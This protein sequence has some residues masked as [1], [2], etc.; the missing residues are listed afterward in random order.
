MNISVIG[1][2]Y[3]GL[4]TGVGL[5]SKGHNVTCVD[6]VKAKVEQISRGASPIYEK[7]L[8]ELL[9]EVTEKGL[10]KATTDLKS[11]VLNS[12]VSFV[13][14][15]TPSEEDGSI[16][17]KY[18]E[19][20]CEDLGKILKNKEEYHTIVIKS[21]V[22]P[23]TTEKVCLPIIEKASGKPAGKGFGICMSPEFLREGLALEDFLNPARHVIGALDEESIKPLLE[24]YKEFDSPIV[25]TDPTT[26]EM[27]KYAANLFLA[28]K[29][30]YVNEIGNL[31]KRL[32]ADVYKVAEALGLDP[33]ISPHF[34]KAGLGFGGSC[35]P[36]DSRALIAKA[37]ELDYNP[38]LL[39]AILQVNKTQVDRLV[40]IAR[41]KAGPLKDKKVAVLGLA[42]KPATD[43]VRESPAIPL[44]EI[45]LKEYANVCVFDPKAMEHTKKIFG[46][47]I[48]YCGTPEEALEDAEL[49][50]LVT[51]WPEFKNLDFSKM[52]EKKVIEGR[53]IL[54][55]PSGLDFEGICW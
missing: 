33:R 50:L 37:K 26:A 30:S 7:G 6:V 27:I 43:D 19:K 12:Q 24:I 21:T 28:T 52:K 4:V 16:D 17:L 2:G 5:A 22:V 38:K 54:E 46:D 31:C 9:A 49:C 15:G 25:L 39:E 34:L 42:F 36:K 8:E 51:A 53:K 1:T 3:V 32:G 35:L 14:V 13:C 41:K 45:L 48:K 10:F 11:A 40:S 29:I 20:A 44:I 55:D 18:I 47:K 23:S